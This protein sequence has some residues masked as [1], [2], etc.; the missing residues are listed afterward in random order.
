YDKHHLRP[1]MIVF[2]AV[3]N[4]ENTMLIKNARG[5][6]CTVVTGVDMFV[7]QACYQ[8]K[9]FTGIDGPADL[10]RSAV[11]RATAAAKY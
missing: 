7:R 6:N 1:S 4:P 5:R 8:F 3:Y 11:K 9:L 2:D 10:M